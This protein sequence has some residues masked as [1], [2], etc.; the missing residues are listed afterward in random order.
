MGRSEHRGDGT[1]PVKVHIGVQVLPV[2][3]AH[4][5][6]LFGADRAEADVF[7]YDRAVF[8]FH[9][10]VVAGVTG[11]R[12][13]LLDQQFVQEA[14]HRVVDELAA[15]VGVK[16]ADDERELLKQV[17][18]DR[19]EPPLRNLRHGSY[20][21]P[22]RDFVDGVEVVHPLAAILIALMYGVPAQVSNEA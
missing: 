2:E 3:L 7:A 16:A 20:D 8:G 1:G 10:T 11:T 14:G 22:L 6:G 15:V 18:Q 12:A 4:G 19:N 17:L 13:G 9:Q 5:L 21:F